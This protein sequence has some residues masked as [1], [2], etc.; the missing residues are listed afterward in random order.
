MLQISFEY[1]NN[2]KEM[3][4]KIREAIAAKL[5]VLTDVMYGK[6]ITNL[7][8]AILN[9]QSGQL[10]SSVKQYVD[11]SSEPMV[12]EVFIDPVTPKALALEYGGKSY[13]LIAPV[14]AQMLHWE[15]GGEYFFRKQVNHPPSKA[16]GYLHVAFEE[17]E[18]LVSEE[19]KNAID[20]AIRL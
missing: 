3:E 14:K 19:F 8:G 6:V 5:V 2:I 18:G 11:T 17:M 1:S 9:K 15:R 7:S 16:Y 10:V 20:E 4:T 12:G 13:Y